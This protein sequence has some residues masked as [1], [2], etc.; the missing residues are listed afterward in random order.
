MTDPVIWEVFA[1]VIGLLL[2]FIGLNWVHTYRSDQ[3]LHARISRQGQRHD[4]YRLE[5]SEKYA[6]VAHLKEVESRLIDEL[7]GLRKDIKD[8]TGALL[9]KNQAVSSKRKGRN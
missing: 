7:K 2:G 5:V 3:S 6:S 9:E 4:D 8:L 1:W